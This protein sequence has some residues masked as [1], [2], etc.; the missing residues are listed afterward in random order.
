M[1]KKKV[2]LW[3]RVAFCKNIL[4]Q[5]SLMYFGYVKEKYIELLYEKK[6]K[7]NDPRK[8]GVSQKLLNGKECDRI[9]FYKFTHFKEGKGWSTPMAESN[10]VSVIIV[11]LCY[12]LEL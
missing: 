8:F 3:P 6:K 7:K 10:Y 4:E 11:F 2:E 5:Y 9:S 12:I 1:S